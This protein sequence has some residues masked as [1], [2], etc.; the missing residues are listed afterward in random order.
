MKGWEFGICNC[1]CPW[2]E[3]ECVYGIS[4][5]SHSLL[6]LLT[7]FEWMQVLS[8]LCG[9]SRIRCPYF[10]CWKKWIHFCLHYLISDS[11]Q[12]SNPFQPRL[13][14]QACWHLLLLTFNLGTTHTAHGE[15]SGCL[16]GSWNYYH[17]VNKADLFF[18]LESFSLMDSIHQ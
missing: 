5:L 16:C 12:F 1:R 2:S 3:D 6:R 4:S 9:L 11:N 10:L 18:H 15:D 8:I 14:L 13:V 7:M 17:N